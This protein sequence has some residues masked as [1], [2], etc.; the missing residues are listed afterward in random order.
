MKKII[1]SK[2]D[3]IRKEKW[4]KSFLTS[5]FVFSSSQCIDILEYVLILDG[6]AKKNARLIDGLLSLIKEQNDFDANLLPKADEICTKLLDKYYLSDAS[7]FDKY[8]QLLLFH[9]Y[10]YA[11]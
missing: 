1:S 11:R 9:F 10:D 5:N 3:N 7:L 4:I 6:A 2:Y 8:S